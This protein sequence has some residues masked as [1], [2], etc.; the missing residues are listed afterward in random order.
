M[1]MQCLNRYSD[2]EKEEE[3]QSA[4]KQK[5]PCSRRCG[6]REQERIEIEIGIRKTCCGIRKRKYDSSRYFVSSLPLT[7]KPVLIAS[8]PGLL[9]V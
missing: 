5:V 4:V 7:A 8:S 6:N 2:H 9:P 3:V 1:L